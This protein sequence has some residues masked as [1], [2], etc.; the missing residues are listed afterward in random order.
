V[1]DVAEDDIAYILG[2][3]LGAPERFSDNDGSQLGRSYIAKLAAKAAYRSAR[4]TYYHDV[5]HLNLPSAFVQ[6]RFR[7]G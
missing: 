6:V 7:A 5:R 1:D 4:R 2:I 3:D